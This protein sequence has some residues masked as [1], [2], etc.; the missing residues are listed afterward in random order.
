MQ[1]FWT[2]TCPPTLIVGSFGDPDTFS[3]LNPFWILQYWRGRSRSLWGP[4]GVRPLVCCA[5]STRMDLARAA[6]VVSWCWAARL[7]LDPDG[8]CVFVEGFDDP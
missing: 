7:L 8:K 4:G 5:L 2:S 1:L 3:F 6:R